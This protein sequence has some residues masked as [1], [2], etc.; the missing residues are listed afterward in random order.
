MV[1]NGIVDIQDARRY[2]DSKDDFELELKGVKRY[3]K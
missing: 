2:A 1:K 3:S